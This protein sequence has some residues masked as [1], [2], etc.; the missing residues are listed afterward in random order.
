MNFD[1]IVLVV[2][3]NFVGSV[4]ML[5]KSVEFYFCKKKKMIK[6]EY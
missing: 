6:Y 5:V 1:L 4:F 2:I 3:D